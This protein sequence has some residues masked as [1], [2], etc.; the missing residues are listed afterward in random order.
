MSG[1]EPQEDASPPTTPRDSV[2]DHPGS[3]VT[4]QRLPSKDPTTT[5]PGLEKS[6][7]L[8]ERALTA[9]KEWIEYEL[10]Q[11][12]S[13]YALMGEMQAVFA[14]EISADS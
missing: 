2:E 3:S 10:G 5:D 8:R 7:E 4:R 14:G 6:G 11:G 9:M 1:L 12:K 13:I